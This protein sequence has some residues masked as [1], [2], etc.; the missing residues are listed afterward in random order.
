MINFPKFSQFVLHVWKERAERLAKSE[1]R[2]KS[3]LHCSV[4]F[5][6]EFNQL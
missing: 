4:L 1:K 6:G 2:E 3:C 5:Y